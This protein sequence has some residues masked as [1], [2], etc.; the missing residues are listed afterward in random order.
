MDARERASRLRY[1]FIGTQAKPADAD[2][3]L[4]SY[5]P[6]SLRAQI[7]AQRLDDVLAQARSADAAFDL[8][9][10]DDERAAPLPHARQQLGLPSAAAGWHAQIDLRATFITPPV[11]ACIDALAQ[12]A[13]GGE[14]K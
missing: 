12:A 10:V 8:R 14:A 11:A 6:A 4:A 5:C 7:A 13:P 3:L 9:V 2:R 1:P